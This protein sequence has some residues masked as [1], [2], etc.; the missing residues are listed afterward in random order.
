M[1][2]D[3]KDKE[4]AE[5]KSGNPEKTATHPPESDDEGG[6]RMGSRQMSESSFYATE[7]DDNDDEHRNTFQLG[8]QC[9]LK[10]QLEKDKVCFQQYC[11]SY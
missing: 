5:D 11:S 9:T 8:P 1:G 3:D 6:N 7:D 4:E 2:F 10:E